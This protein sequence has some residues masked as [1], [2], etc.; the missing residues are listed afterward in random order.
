M[1]QIKISISAFAKYELLQKNL[2]K[3]KKRSAIF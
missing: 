3:A 1:G 2:A